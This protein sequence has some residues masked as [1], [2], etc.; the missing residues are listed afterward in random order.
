MKVYDFIIVLKSPGFRWVDAVS[1]LMLLLA[2]TVF[3]FSIS[4]VSFN[5]RSVI[6]L[7]LIMAI[8]GWWFF[9]S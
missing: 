4:F 9:V 7:F 8:M 2:I 3:G 6:V 5:I 1:K